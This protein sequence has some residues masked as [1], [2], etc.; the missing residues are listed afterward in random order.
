MLNHSDNIYNMTQVE[1]ANGNETP[2]EK[3]Q[4]LLRAT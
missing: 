4:G 2:A 1:F 3:H